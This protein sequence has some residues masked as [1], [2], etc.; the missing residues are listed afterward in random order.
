MLAAAG[1]P[2]L[3]GRALLRLQWRTRA[4]YKCSDGS[5]A[6]RR[7]IRGARPPLQHAQQR[8][9][10][11]WTPAAAAPSA[12]AQP[13]EQQQEQ[14]QEQ[15]QP[16]ISVLLQEVLGFFEGVSVERYVDGTLGAAGHASEVLRRHPELTTLVGF[17]LDTSAHIIAAARLEAAGARV[18]RVVPACGPGGA[19]TLPAEFQRPA[20]GGAGSSSEEDGSGSGGLL[21]T[22]SAPTAFIVHSNFGA[23][24]PVLAQL[25]GGT[26]AGAVDAALLDLGM[27]SMQ[28]I[29]VRYG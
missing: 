17:D 14:G 19:V 25:R 20:G 18:V 5:S 27:S 6:C 22:P 12:H 24:G 7:A 3:E 16:H 4:A 23:M 11:L 26:L 21:T 28:V 15:Q 13:Q 1:R 29:R 9:R 10:P 8:R 2:L